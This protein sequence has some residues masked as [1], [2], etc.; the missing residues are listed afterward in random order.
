VIKAVLFDFGLVISTPRPPGRFREYESKLGLAEGTINQIMFESRAWQ[1]ALVGR[2]S[3][4]AFWYSIGPSLNLT[5]CKEIDD[6]RHRY[7]A[8]EFADPGIVSLIRRLH[9]KTC[10]AVLSNHPPGLDQWL[11]EWQIRHFFDVVIASGDVGCTKPDPKIYQISLERLDVRP[12]E[13][14]FIDDTPGHVAAAQTLGIHGIVF[15]GTRQLV[16]DLGALL[17]F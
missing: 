9:G 15:V 6:F 11:E 7:Y 4:Q 2:M 1:E 3:M 17:T 8:D 5:H 10:L 16:R 13:T 12:H 14:V